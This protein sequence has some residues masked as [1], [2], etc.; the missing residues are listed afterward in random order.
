MVYDFPLRSTEIIRVVDKKKL[1][2]NN[3][4]KRQLELFWGKKIQ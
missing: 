1:V 3:Y 2:S 4:L